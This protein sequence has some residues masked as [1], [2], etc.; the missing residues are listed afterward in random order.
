MGLSR[1]GLSTAMVGAMGGRWTDQ[2]GFGN[3]A[4]RRSRY[5][6]L[7]KLKRP[8]WFWRGVKLSG[9][10][11]NF[12]LLSGSFGFFSQEEELSAAWIYLTSMGIGFE[13]F[14]KQAVEWAV[15]RNAKIGFNPGTRQITAGLAEMKYA[16]AK[17]EVLFVNREEAGKLVGWVRET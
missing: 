4:K 3:I 13:D 17:T 1:L 15:K 12:V 6:N 14:Y 2:K 16:F 5:K 10:T 9:G 11:D 8:K 7:W